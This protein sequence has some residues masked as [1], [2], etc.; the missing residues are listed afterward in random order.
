[1]FE[2]EFGINAQVTAVL[3]KSQS[4]S[5][6]VISNR[7]VTDDEKF[8]YKINNET[9]NNAIIPLGA[10][11]TIINHDA[12]QKNTSNLIL[13]SLGGRMSG[14]ICNTLGFNLQITNTAM[15][16]GDTALSL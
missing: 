4:D 14:T 16:K 1:M 10:F 6:Q 3:I 13:G 8:I 2:K 15:L 7:I 5:I 12:E 11:E 9:L